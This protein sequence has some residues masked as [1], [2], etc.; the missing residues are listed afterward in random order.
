VLAGSGHQAYNLSKRGFDSPTQYYL[1]E[2]GTIASPYSIQDK[3]GI[4][5]THRSLC[6]MPIVTLLF[7]LLVLSVGFNF[8]F[9]EKINKL[10]HVVSTITSPVNDDE[11]KKLME[12]I[13]R[14]SKQTYTSGTKYDIKTREPIQNDF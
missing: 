12:E 5:M 1:V 10:N 8:I 3:Q 4:F 13:K 14:L 7:G 2:S 6:C 11:L 9:V